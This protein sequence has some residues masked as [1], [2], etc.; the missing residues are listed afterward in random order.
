MLFLTTVPA[1]SPLRVAVNVLPFV[2]EFYPYFFDDTQEAHPIMR[3]LGI[4]FVSERSLSASGGVDL[5]FTSRLA[6]AGDE[7][8]LHLDNGAGGLA[9]CGLDRLDNGTRQLS[10]P[11]HHCF[12][13]FLLKVFS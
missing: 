7:V 10:C 6:I 4:I 1:I 8:I 13:L 5:L 3:P 2:K 11:L 12:P 9:R